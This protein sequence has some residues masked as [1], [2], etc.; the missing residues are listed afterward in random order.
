M[1]L[2]PYGWKGRRLPLSVIARQSIVTKVDPEMRRRVF[3]IMVAAGQAGHGLGIGEAWR[4]SETQL[5]GFLR[6]HDRVPKGGCCGYEGKRYALKPHTAHMA[7]PGRSYHET[8]TP[9]GFCLAVDMV[10]DLKWM[11]AKAELFGLRHFGTINNEPWHIQPVEV[12]NSRAG[13]KPTM[14]P[15]PKWDFPK[16]LDIL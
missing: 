2:Y 13:Y 4:S 16:S 8:T 10:G 12:P 7:P 11:N 9:S 15:L 1:T 14:D 3:A 6:R 5:A